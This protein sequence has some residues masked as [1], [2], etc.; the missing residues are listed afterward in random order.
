[1]NTCLNPQ[2]ATSIIPT[3][4]PIAKRMADYKGI[5]FQFAASHVNYSYRLSIAYVDA[6]KSWGFNSQ[7]ATSIIPTTVI[8]FRLMKKHKTMCRNPQRA[9]SIISALSR[10]S[11][12][13]KRIH[14]KVEIRSA[15]CQLF[16]FAPYVEVTNQ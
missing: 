10:R 11:F 12:E 15:P 9:T 16:L 13:S 14:C 4:I 3:N 7:Q 1:M 6:I 5:S 2:Q 8:E